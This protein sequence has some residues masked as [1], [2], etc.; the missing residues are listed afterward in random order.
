MPSR[1]SSTMEGPFE[2][3]VEK[4]LWEPLRPLGHLAAHPYHRVS[5]PS[6]LVRFLTFEN[7]TQRLRSTMAFRRSCVGAGW[8]CEWQGHQGPIATNLGTYPDVLVIG[9]PYQHRYRQIFFTSNQ[10]TYEISS[11]KYSN[12]FTF[13]EDPHD[14]DWVKRL[15]EIGLCFRTNGLLEHSESTWGF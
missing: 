9:N 3:A 1:G 7:N 13:D 5:R 10:K 4:R 2:S 6:D 11:L 12:E 8:D 15:N 14:S